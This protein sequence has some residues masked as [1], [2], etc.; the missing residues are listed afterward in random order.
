MIQY[1]FQ[2]ILYCL[3]GTVNQAILDF[4]VPTI[5]HI[6]TTEKTA[7]TRVIAVNNVAVMSMDAYSVNVSS[8]LIFI[9]IY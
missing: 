5:V 8:G 3:G 6:L 2:R 7:I 1:D 9:L 4:F